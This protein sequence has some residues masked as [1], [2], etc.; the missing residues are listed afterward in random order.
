MLRPYATNS[1]R[2]HVPVRAA[3][4]HAPMCPSVPVLP[5]LAAH[6]VPVS[7][8]PYEL[9]SEDLFKDLNV[10]PLW[11]EVDVLPTHMPIRR[12]FLELRLF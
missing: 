1:S 12:Q 2:P 6:D 11:H 10:L 9:K 4:V 3:P 8:C 5:T 7:P